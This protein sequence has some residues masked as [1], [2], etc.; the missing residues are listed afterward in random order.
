MLVVG[1]DR[2]VHTLDIDDPS[3]PTPVLTDVE[4]RQLCRSADDEAVYAATNSGL[5]RSTDESESWTALEVPH[6]EVASVFETPDGAALF[7]GTQPAHVYRSTDDGATWSRCEAFER[8]PGR[9]SWAQLGPGGPQVRD[10]TGHPH[11]PGTVYAAVESEG[12]YVTPDHGETWER[13]SRGLQADPHALHALAQDALVASCGRGLYRTRDAGRTWIRL[14]TDRELFWY[15][16]YREAIEHEGV[17]YASAQDRSEARHDPPGGGVIVASD[18]DGRTLA[19][20]DDFPGADG[21][22]VNAWT[23]TDGQVVGG[24]IHGRIL[25]GPGPWEERTR[26]DGEIRSLTVTRGR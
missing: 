19:L 8:I 6:D 7:A 26:L 9:E 4:V 22:Y 5:Y 14:D 1:T 21:D 15:S 16:Y 12:V 23:T 17:L 24:T 11:A 10:L 3:S 20:H 25:V 2:A 13:R 18:D